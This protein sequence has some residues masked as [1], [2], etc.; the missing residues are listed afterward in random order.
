MVIIFSLIKFNITIEDKYLPTNNIFDISFY[1]KTIVNNIQLR[2]ANENGFDNVYN[3]YINN[4]A[5]IEKIT[6]LS[7]L[8]I[9]M[10][11]AKNDRLLLIIKTNNN[12]E[13]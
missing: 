13:V 7:E 5:N 2:K 3:R 10:I 9:I 6:L 4:I 8:L 12:I 1:R 11:T